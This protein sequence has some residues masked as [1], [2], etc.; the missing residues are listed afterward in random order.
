MEFEFH[1]DALAEF[2]AET[3][4]YEAIE[5]GLGREF[6][7]EILRV[8]ELARLF[9]NIG[10]PEEGNVRSL[11]AKRFPFLIYYEIMGTKLWIWAV[12][13]AA[14]E[15]GYWKSRKQG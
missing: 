3:T 14:R 15:R 1:P 5:S 9:P 2:K 4:Y 6:A 10:S 11:L 8:I 12:M 7:D 13:H